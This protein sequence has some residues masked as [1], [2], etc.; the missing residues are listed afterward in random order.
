MTNTITSSPTGNGRRLL[1]RPPR[2][3]KHPRRSN[4]ARPHDTQPQPPPPAPC[5]NPT[6]TPPTPR[7]PRLRL[8]IAA[9]AT[10]ATIS[11][12]APSIP[13]QPSVVRAQGPHQEVLPKRLC[14]GVGVGVAQ[15]RHCV[16]GFFSRPDS[17]ADSAGARHRPGSGTGSR[18]WGGVLRASV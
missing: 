7:P 11:A 18:L 2:P 3:R 16:G 14:E 8:H 13:R 6:T 9:P 15:V 17:D 12:L 4:N 5:P 10:A 1:R